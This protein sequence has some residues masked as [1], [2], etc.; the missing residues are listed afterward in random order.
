METETNFTSTKTDL[1]A[2]GGA[3]F[4][5]CGKYRYSLWRIWDTEE[6]P[7]AF[8]G[9][10]PSKAGAVK[11]DNTITKVIKIA[12]NNG[13]GGIYMLNCFPLISTDPNALVGTDRTVQM[14]YNMQIIENITS[15]CNA[16]VFAWGG[17]KIVTDSKIDTILKYKFP[18]SLCLHINADGSPKHPLYC[19]DK[20][21][22]T[23][24]I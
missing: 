20:T 6:Q 7:V 2:A 21:I 18:N 11:N 10:N 14:A 13:F 23:P 4:S 3:N 22:L 17:F 5:S 1:F 12:K 19:A 24:Y 8:I 15:Q 9:L 16:V